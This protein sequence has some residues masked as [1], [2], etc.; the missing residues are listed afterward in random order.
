MPTIIVIPNTLVNALVVEADNVIKFSRHPILLYPFDK[1]FVVR[2]YLIH[3]D[4]IVFINSSDRKRRIEKLRSVAGSVVVWKIFP[5]KSGMERLQPATNDLVKVGSNNPCRMGSG[6]GTCDLHIEPQFLRLGI[7]AVNGGD[8]LAN[9][10]VVARLCLIAVAMRWKDQWHPLVLHC[11]D[12][13]RRNVVPCSFCIVA[14]A[15]PAQV[16]KREAANGTK[17]DLCGKFWHVHEPHE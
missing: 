17:S 16:A 5:I 14:E 7:L 13:L 15:F 6:I 10:F 4:A 3:H 12:A 11:K 1:Q 8:Q 2:T 9:D